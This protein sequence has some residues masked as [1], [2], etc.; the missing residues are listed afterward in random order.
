MSGGADLTAAELAAA[1][2]EGRMSATE[3]VEDALE[4][5]ASL[6][7]ALNCF[8]AVFAERALRS[9]RRIDESGGKG[10]GP[11][12]GVPFAVKNLY[13]VEGEVTLAGSIIERDRPPAGRDAPLVS[14]LESAGSIR[15]GPC[16]AS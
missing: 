6:D 11:L 8:T 14:R 3:V 2:R 1:V 7:G 9:A 15:S 16:I 10:A 5:I 12:A 4:R 13:D